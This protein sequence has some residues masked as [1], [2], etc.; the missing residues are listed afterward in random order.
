MP[1]NSAVG[2]ALRAAIAAG[3]IVG[4]A[5]VASAEETPDGKALYLQH[6]AACH[7]ANG[8]GVPNF[9]PSL[10][11]SPIVNGPTEKLEA[12]IWAGSSF[13]AS[14]RENP[15]GVTMPPFGY[16]SG[17][18]AK[19]IVAYVLEAFGDARSAQAED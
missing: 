6:C 12:T 7:M 17:E 5:R 9:Q 19:A 10:V 3:A 8:R 1:G 2:S 11:G 18:E 4:G 15:F 13:L 16:L 14:Q